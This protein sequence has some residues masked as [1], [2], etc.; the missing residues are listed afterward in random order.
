[1]TY[2]NT[3]SEELPFYNQW[4]KEVI[5]KAYSY[6]FPTDI[7]STTP[8]PELDAMIKEHE[9]ELLEQAR[10]SCGINSS[11]PSFKLN[12]WEEKSVSLATTIIIKLLNQVQEVNG[13]FPWQLEIMEKA[14]KYALPY[15]L[16][17]PNWSKLE[18]QIEDLEEVL[19]LA[20][21][22]NICTIDYNGIEDLRQKIEDAITRETRDLYALRRDYNDS[23]L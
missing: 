8:P 4:K 22:Y 1:M 20:N 21:M 23:R 6:N 19:A 15:N 5:N 9:Y 13:Y 11:F 16:D 7:I 18:Q 12:S 17:N 14:D 3:V 10:R 2:T